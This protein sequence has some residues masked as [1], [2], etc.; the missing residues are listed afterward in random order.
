MQLRDRIEK[1]QGAIASLFGGLKGNLYAIGEN[2]AS[3]EP[4]IGNVREPV[5]RPVPI[6]E[7]RPTQ[8]TVGMREV[9]ARQKRWRTHTDERKRVEFLQKHLIP[10]I[11]GPGSRHYILDHHHLA[12]ALDKEGLAELYV[13]VVADL[14][15][16]DKDT[17]WFV[18]DQHNWMH[19]F[20]RKGVRRSYE[21]IPK[22]VREMQ[23][24]PYRSLAGELRRL[25][26]FAKDT[27]P[28]S[29]F[30]WADFLRRRLKTKL[31]ETDFP[32]ALQSA[33]KLAKG[34]E[35]E[36]LPGWCGPSKG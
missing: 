10:V 2:M 16:L 27:T 5:L 21:K 8:I 28:Y 34:K 30:L 36:Y 14:S 31:V 32:R 15:A 7:L 17:F 23:D 3:A 6:S 9:L 18:L 20:D 22:S 13:T 4:S 26:G 12:F 35:A 11:L 33:L 29:E 24:D 1:N 19:P 25:G